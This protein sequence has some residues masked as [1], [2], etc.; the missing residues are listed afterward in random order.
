[1]EIAG[2]LPVWGVAMFSTVFG[3][4]AVRDVY[5]RLRDRAAVCCNRAARGSLDTTVDMIASSR[6]NY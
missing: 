6:G 4:G 5:V 2:R 1:M 3:S